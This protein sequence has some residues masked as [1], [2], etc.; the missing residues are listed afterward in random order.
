MQNKV[1]SDSREFSS[2]SDIVKRNSEKLLNIQ[3]INLDSKTQYISLTD[4]INCISPVNL[5]SSV[6]YEAS[7]SQSASDSLN[8]YP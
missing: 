2:H 7:V 4:N 6:T 1:K 5:N 8:L 3:P